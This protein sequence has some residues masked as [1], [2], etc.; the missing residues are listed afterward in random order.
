MPCTVVLTIN[1]HAFDLQDLIRQRPCWNRYDAR[2][3]CGSKAQ[4]THV[5]PQQ[6]QLLVCNRQPGGLLNIA[7]GSLQQHRCCLQFHL[8]FH[9]T[10]NSLSRITPAN[11]DKIRHSSGA[12]KVSSILIGDPGW[13][14]TIDLPLRRRPLY[15]LSYGALPARQVWRSSLLPEYG[16]WI[17]GGA[18][19]GKRHCS[20]R[21]I[22]D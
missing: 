13:I 5:A 12:E 4:L 19:C 20:R 21:G 22:C 14:R 1:D 10:A 11:N 18:P 16:S 2:S 15:P 6:F 17:V 8:S 7:C 3:C 9:P